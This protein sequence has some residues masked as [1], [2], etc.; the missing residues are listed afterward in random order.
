MAVGRRW[1]EAIMLSY[2]ARNVDP[3]HMTWYIKQDPSL[4]KHFH[5][6]FTVVQVR[7]TASGWLL[8]KKKY[9]LKYDH[10]YNIKEGSV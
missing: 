10:E 7:L 8:L 2:N 5:S 3:D 4:K 9:P 1:P 6:M